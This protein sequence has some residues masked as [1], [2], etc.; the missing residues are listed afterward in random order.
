V[1][2][3]ST[4]HV[5]QYIGCILIDNW[6]ESESENWRLQATVSLTHQ[7]E[8]EPEQKQILIFRLDL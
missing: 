2:F 8:K 1:W 4:V 7:P 3:F 6:S 5:G